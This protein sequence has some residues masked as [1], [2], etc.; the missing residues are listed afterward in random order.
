MVRKIMMKLLNFDFLDLGLNVL[1]HSNPKSNQG[2]QVK[3]K[4]KIKLLQSL[5]TGKE[6]KKSKTPIFK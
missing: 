5:L 4:V 2:S 6:K 3:V 1:K